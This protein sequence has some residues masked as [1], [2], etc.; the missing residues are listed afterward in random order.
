MI[1]LGLVMAGGA[2]ASVLQIE[3]FTALAPNIFG[4]LSY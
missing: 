3:V 2:H 4:S 1:A